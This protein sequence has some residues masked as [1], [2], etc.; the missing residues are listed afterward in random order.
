LIQ[1]INIEPYGKSGLKL[2]Y[3]ETTEPFESKHGLMVH[4]LHR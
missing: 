1:S 2:F 3:C 4:L